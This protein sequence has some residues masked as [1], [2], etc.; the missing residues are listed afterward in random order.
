MTKVLWFE[1]QYKDLEQFKIQAENQGFL[2]E[3]YESAEKSC[4]FGYN[5]DFHQKYFTEC[6]C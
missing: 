5:I 1:D 2:L 6:C 3:G 4:S